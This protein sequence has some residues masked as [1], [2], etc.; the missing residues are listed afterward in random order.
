MNIIYLISKYGKII[1]DKNDCKVYGIYDG[2]RKIISIEGRDE[3]N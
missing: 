2:L 1:S 3:K